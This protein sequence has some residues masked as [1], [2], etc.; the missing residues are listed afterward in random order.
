MS[1]S[2]ETT[3]RQVAGDFAKQYA[4]P[5]HIVEEEL[6]HKLKAHAD[7]FNEVLPRKLNMRVDLTM[8]GGATV[9]IENSEG[10]QKYTE[11]FDSVISEERSGGGLTKRMR[12]DLF[13]EATD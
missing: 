10:G 13:L 6:W 8:P 1:E 5:R 4:L 2:F 9:L 12:I 7:P 3:V 11:R